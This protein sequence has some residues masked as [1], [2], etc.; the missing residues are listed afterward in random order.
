MTGNR[1]S[2]DFS[3]FVFASITIEITQSSR[4]SLTQSQRKK[5]LTK[6]IN[7]FTKTTLTFHICNW[8]GRRGESRNQQNPW[9]EDTYDSHH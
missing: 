3:G 2:G 1:I 8:M 4:L 7:Q 5:A 9:P 6:I